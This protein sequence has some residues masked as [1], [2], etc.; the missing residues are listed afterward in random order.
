MTDLL[1]AHS[2]VVTMLVGLTGWIVWTAWR[3]RG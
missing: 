1:W 3:E 2:V